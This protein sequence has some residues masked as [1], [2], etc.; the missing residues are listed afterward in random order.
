MITPLTDEHTTT[1]ENIS[2]DHVQ[3]DENILYDKGKVS[4]DETGLEAEQ[5]PIDDAWFKQ[6]SASL[7]K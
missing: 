7:S 5:V 1:I 2:A 6:K 3:D 4:H